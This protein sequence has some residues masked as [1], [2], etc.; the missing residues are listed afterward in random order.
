[1]A[2]DTQANP[3]W[4]WGWQFWTPVVVVVLAGA[5]STAFLRGADLSNAHLHLAN[6]SG[7]DLSKAALFGADLSEANIGESEFYP[8]NPFYWN[9]LRIPTNL[10]DTNLHDTNLSGARLFGA[11]LIEAWSLTQQQLDAACGTLVQ[12]DPGLT[13]EPCPPPALP[14]VR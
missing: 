7:A 4:G 14:G 5:V 3:R 9:G 1:M 10:S 12:L 13:I 8:F 11:N 2:T 6:L